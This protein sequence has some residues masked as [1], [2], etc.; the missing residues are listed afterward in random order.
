MAWLQ[1]RGGK[2]WIGWRHNGK[3][4]RKSLKT[5]DR[6]TA[7]AQVNR[8][9]AVDA[10]KRANSLTADYIAA[11]TGQATTS[12]QTVA[13]YLAAWLKEAVATTTKSTGLKYSQV[14]NEFLESTG[15]KSGGLLM[16][17]VTVGHVRTFLTEKR[18]KSSPGTVKGFKRILGSAFLQAQNDGTITGNPV[19]LAKLR[20]AKDKDSRRKRPF[21]LA[22]V[23]DLH[24]LATPFWKFMIVAGFHSGQS[25]GDLIT[26]SPSNVNFD[27]GMITISRRKTG[28][29][30]AIPISDA[31]RVCLTQKCPNK[32]R[33]FFW[34]DEAAR[35]LKTGASPFSQEF[36]DLLAS[37]GLVAARGLKSVSTGKGRAAKRANAILGFHNLRHTF[38]TN[39][40]VSGAVDSVAREL[41]GHSSTD[42]SMIYTHLPAATLTDAIKQLPSFQ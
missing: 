4:F 41:A 10:A 11:I 15:A 20:G 17:E 14:I 22:E 19:A 25:L 31:L 40:K 24:T 5:G 38:V 28:K 7:E 37:A 23:K 36:F 30:V 27:E 21:T 1:K 32:T 35:Y 9:E 3:Q 12:K 6:A 13:D 39:L 29:R 18:I 42:V 8:L 26:L 16:E 33:E 34:P 2:W